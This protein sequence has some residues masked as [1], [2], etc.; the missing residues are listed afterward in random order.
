MSDKDKCDYTG[1]PVNGDDMKP[2]VIY[3]VGPNAEFYEVEPKKS[4]RHKKPAP[5]KERQWSR[6]LKA[7]DWGRADVCALVNIVIRYF[8]TGDIETLLRDFEPH[9]SRWINKTPISDSE[10]EDVHAYIVQRVDIGGLTWANINYLVNRTCFPDEI[11]IM[12]GAFVSHLEPFRSE[13]IELQAKD[14]RQ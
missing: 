12:A 1:S 2:G 7:Y 13:W 4:T 5:D 9:V 11:E 14:T 6:E 3:R 10:R 8:D